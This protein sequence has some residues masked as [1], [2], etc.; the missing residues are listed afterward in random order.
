MPVKEKFEIDGRPAVPVRRVVVHR[1]SQSREISRYLESQGIIARVDQEEIIDFALSRILQ[2]AGGD[3][4]PAETNGTLNNVSS[5]RVLNIINHTGLTAA[6][7]LD[8]LRKL[9]E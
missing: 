1:L 2:I 9:E 6:Y 7:F 3:L 8:S 5:G 4:S